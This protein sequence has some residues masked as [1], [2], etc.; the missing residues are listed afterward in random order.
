MDKYEN[1]AM[2]LESG[3]A[4][5]ETK[6]FAHAIKLLSPIA[7]EGNVEAMYRMAIM[8]QNGL[9]CQASTQKAFDYMG[10]AAMKGYPLAQ[11]AFGFM[12]F[13]GEC[14]DKD[15]EK[16]IEWFTKAADQGLMGSATTLAMIYEEG[17]LVPQDLDKAQH[18]YKKAGIEKP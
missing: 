18:W 11:H 8:L 2:E 12:F 3:I 6:S 1:R 14:T 17:K 10:S 15:I 7:D 4:A 5:F 13:E 9:G 16:S